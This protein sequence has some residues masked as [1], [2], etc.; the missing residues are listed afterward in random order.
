M[1]HYLR[2]VVLDGL[3]DLLDLLALGVLDGVQLLGLFLGSL[4]ENVL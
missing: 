1:V 3:V 4:R 2:L